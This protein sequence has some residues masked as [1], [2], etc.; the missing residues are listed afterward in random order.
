MT[1]L[2]ETV[3]ALTQ[4]GGESSKIFAKYWNDIFGGL[5]KLTGKIE[6]FESAKSVKGLFELIA[7][8]F[9]IT[10]VLVVMLAVRIVQHIPALWRLLIAILEI[11]DRHCGKGTDAMSAERYQM[12]YVFGENLWRVMLEN[13]DGFKLHAKGESY[14][15]MPSNKF[16]LRDGVWLY[17]YRCRK[18]DT[19]TFDDE[20][21]EYIADAV[22]DD[23]AAML[24]FGFFDGVYQPCSYQF[25]VVDVA[26]RGDHIL[27]YVL[28]VENES[29]IAFIN[30]G[31]AV[32]HETQG[33]TK[34]MED[35]DFGKKPE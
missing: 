2:L 26:D 22:N 9:C 15:L 34:V 24:E 19:A 8:S 4:F 6:R 21:L 13:Q 10:A 7:Y 27:A 5:E 3:A 30:K 31:N 33:G 11:I 17:C 18:T 28:F 35:D 29:D 20:H 23:I 1:V 16:V 25:I 12:Y 14:K 32:N